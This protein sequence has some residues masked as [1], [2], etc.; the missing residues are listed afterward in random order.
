MIAMLLSTS[1]LSTETR[2]LLPDWRR[3]PYVYENSLSSAAMIGALR[4]FSIGSPELRADRPLPVHWHD[5]FEIGYV[6]EGSGLFVIEDQEY[7]FQPGQVHVIND[8]YRHMAYAFDRARFLN[9]HFHPSLLRDAGFPELESAALRPF[10]VGRQRFAPLLPVGDPRT[11]QIISLIRAIGE[12]HA[13]GAT[14]WSLVVKGL[15]LQA[16]GLLL[17]HFL[18]DAPADA[19]QRRRQEALARLAPSLRLLEQR[20]LNPPALRDLAAEVALSPSH[21]SALFHEATGSSPVAYRNARRI[22]HAQRLL[23]ESDESIAR[24]AEQCGF[25]TIQQFN[26]VFRRQT[27]ATPGSYRT[28]MRAAQPP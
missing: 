15:I 17:R 10:S 3:V 13:A 5:A 1:V 2:N 7:L 9:V 23:L 16:I 14:G 26:R 25:V 27:G 24:I 11:E 18:S 4:P 22:S 8:T 19:A 28:R 21:F 6:L 20:L 12:E